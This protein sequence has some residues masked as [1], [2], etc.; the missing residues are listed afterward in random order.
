MFVPGLGARVVECGYLD[1]AVFHPRSYKLH[2]NLSK[3]MG[4]VPL[5]SI[6]IQN[7]RLM[8]SKA[9]LNVMKGAPSLREQ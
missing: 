7:P 8:T 3:G 4:L 6:K 1:N 2:W 5:N 9:P